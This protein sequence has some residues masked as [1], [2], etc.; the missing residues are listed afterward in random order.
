MER[1][2]LFAECAVDDLSGIADRMRQAGHAALAGRID[3]GL[4]SAAREGIARISVVRDFPI[5]LVGYGYTREY[6]TP[7][8]A[9]LAPL[10]HG[11]GDKLP[12][13]TVEAR[14][15]GLLVELDPLL[16]WR[17]CSVNGWA[18][19]PPAAADGEQASGWL[20]DQMYASPQSEAA[21]AIRRVTHAYSHLLMHALAYHS[22]YSSNSVAEYLLE[23]QASTLVYVAKYTSFNLG[24]LTALAEQHLQTMGRIRDRECLVMRARPGMPVRARRL[25]QMPGRRVRLRAVQHRAGPRLP[26][27]RRPARHPGRIPVHR[28]AGRARL[29]PTQHQHALP[30]PELMTPP[31]ARCCTATR[32]C[33][34]TH[35]SSSTSPAR[36]AIEASIT[37]VGTGQ[38]KKVCVA[39]TQAAGAPGRSTLAS[40]AKTR[41]MSSKYPTSIRSVLPR[42]AR[43]ALRCRSHRPQ[44]RQ[45]R[46]VIQHQ[47]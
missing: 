4:D 10:P 20:L 25:P 34:S 40:S 8:K 7:A 37:S 1:A 43:A 38:P 42:S 46:R 26:R 17:W 24:G 16:L 31:R 3:D 44:H 19:P 2:F 33:R 35:S 9:K 13:I 27:R 47:Q 12:L 45:D 21:T 6:R 11:D 32:L 28:P 14:T 15:E 23:R 39:T 5:A 36:R 41:H 29:R 22:S 30:P 18:T